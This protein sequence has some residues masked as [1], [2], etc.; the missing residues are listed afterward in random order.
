MPVADPVIIL[1]LPRSYSS[2]ACAILGQHPQM[3][4]LL[5][6]QLF[7]VDLML[8][9]WAEYGEENHDADGLTRVVA[10]VVFGHQCERTVEEA[11]EWLWA[12]RTCTAA[13]VLRELGEHLYPLMMIEK[14]PMEG[15]DDQEVRRKLQRQIQMFPQA[16]FL[17]LV[18]HPKA[19]GRS[20]LEHLEVMSRASSYPARMAR[21]YARML[22]GVIIDPQVL[23]YRVNANIE[24]FLAGLPP[25]RHLRIRG[26]DLLADPDPQLRRIT[27]WLGLRCDS[28]VIEQMKHPECSPFACLGPPNATFG[29]DPNF[30]RDPAL[31]LGRCRDERLEGPVPWRSD[32]RGLSEEVRHLARQFGYCDC[33]STA[34]CGTAAAQS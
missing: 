21:R 3:Y 34:D 5:E 10:E 12:R 9:W 33:K 20:H 19:Y 16:R 27:S 13:D 8:Q 30:F 18:R 2:L 17:H 11:Q 15:A 23:W 31:R 25:E 28:G 32:G 22:E 24:T 29:G 14:T 1:A 6:T 7:E 26:E 4:D